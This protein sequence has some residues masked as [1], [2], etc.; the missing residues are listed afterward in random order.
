MSYSRP[1]PHPRPRPRP[2]PRKMAAVYT[3]KVEES[4]PS[5]GDTP[6]AGPVYRNIYAKDGLLELP[7]GMNCPWEF[8]RYSNQRTVAGPAMPS[9]AESGRERL[10]G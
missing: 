3:V 8:F 7:E 5:I 6:S 2:R 1:R 9:F 4:R 10:A